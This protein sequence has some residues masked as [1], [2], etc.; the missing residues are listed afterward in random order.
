M[1]IVALL[2][3]ALAVVFAVLVISGSSPSLTLDLRAFKVDTSLIGVYISGILTIV[4]AAVGLWLLR[5][6]LRRSRRRRSEVKQLR[7][8]ARTDPRI[9][10]DP[11][12][13]S[14]TATPAADPNVDN[15][16]NSPRDEG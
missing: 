12:R 4:V 14:A 5:A 2:L 10:A 13:G 1:V 6:G 7:R 3:I 11:S 9:S 8:A 15:H 16:F